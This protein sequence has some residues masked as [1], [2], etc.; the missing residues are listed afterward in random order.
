MVTP[1]VKRPT[2]PK[3]ALQPH[4]VMVKIGVTLRLRR[5]VTHSNGW[6]NTTRDTGAEPYDEA[7]QG[8]QTR[9]Q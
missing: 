6:F 3:I 7:L 1:K 9:R 4:F 5:I 8:S 2:T